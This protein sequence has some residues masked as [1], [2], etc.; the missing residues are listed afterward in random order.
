MSNFKQLQQ[1]I[2]ENSNN[3]TNWDTTI[4]EWKML[5]IEKV[6]HEDYCLCGKEIKNLLIT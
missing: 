4:A 2:I 5:Y 1:I 3:T 6:E